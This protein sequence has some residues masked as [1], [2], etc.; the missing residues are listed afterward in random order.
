[1]SDFYVTVLSQSDNAEFPQNVAHSFKNRL[2]SPLFL[3]G[4]G[5]KVGLSSISLPDSRVDLSP[6][7]Q[8]SLHIA[9]SSWY[10][11]YQ[12]KQPSQD[13]TWHLTP[14]RNKKVFVKEIENDR[15]IID[16]ISF[17]KSMLNSIEQERIKQ[18]RV[19]Y[20]HQ[21]ED[22]KD[23]FIRFAW[24]ED[25]I[26]IDNTYT[27]LDPNSRPAIMFGVKLAEKMGW[28]KRLRD[29]N[30]ELGP[31]LKQEFISNLVPEPQDYEVKGQTG[32]GARKVFWMAD[33]TLMH[34]S[35]YCNWRFVD[36]NKAFRSVVGDPSRTFHIYSDVCESS[37][38]GNMMRDL[39]REIQYKRV[40][41]GSVY[42]EPLHIQY[43]PIR[44][45]II[46]T[47]ETAVA[48]SETGNLVNFG[49]GEC[50]LTLHFKKGS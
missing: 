45:D 23:L 7:V 22:G 48:E 12:P 44:N 4:D 2:A 21:D 27:S 17:M 9:Y 11:R 1:M 36:L 29:G 31:N 5:W 25:E 32:G 33:N 24:Q 42:F 41:R 49:K 3:T 30:H 13:K 47:I 14:K 50:I 34:L 40:G 10:E 35:V 18:T 28:L 37:M 26:L 19:G 16:G 15:E 38:I 46:E 43:I 39:L 8:G 6:L 20:N